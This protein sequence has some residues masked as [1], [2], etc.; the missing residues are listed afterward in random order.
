M[1]FYS[2]DD[3]KE[4]VKDLNIKIIAIDKYVYRVHILYSNNDAKALDGIIILQAHLIVLYNF[5]DKFDVEVIIEKMRKIG[6]KKV[7]QGYVDY[8]CNNNEYIHLLMIKNSDKV[9]AKLLYIINKI[10]YLL[11]TLKL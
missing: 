8:T 11:L 10:D 5:F 4:F 6:I 7:E 1:Y 3:L 9:K 2:V